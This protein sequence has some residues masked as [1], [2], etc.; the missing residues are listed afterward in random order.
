MKIKV[1]KHKT[2]ALALAV[3][4]FLTS[5]SLVYSSF[6][7]KD[8]N[9]FKDASTEDRRIA[10]EISNETGVAVDQVFDLKI[11][12][13]SW[14]K[15]LEILKTRVNSKEKS[16]KAQMQNTLVNSGLDEDFLKKLKK[17]GFPDESITQVKM[18]EERVVFQLQE[19]S[20][21]SSENQIK[22][23]KPDTDFIKVKDDDKRTFAELTKKID[24][25]DAVY[26]MLKLEK[27]FGS[28]EKVFDEYML[29]LQLDI[30]LNEYIKD[31][32]SY[33]KKRDEKKLLLDEK[34]TITLEKIEAKSIELLQKNNK[35]DD[36]GLLEK[37]AAKSDINKNGDGDKS[38]L[39]DIPHVEVENIKPQNPTD[40]V[41]NEIKEIN[42][43][44]K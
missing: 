44:N 39:P 12:G 30:D 5:I 24:I 32:K 19:I 29:A 25:K 35:S 20:A 8:R 14:E 33:E 34:D 1:K 42:P 23:D 15:V 40:E 41:M 38:Q 13:R 17:E 27:A 9:T 7:E 2:V 3:A 28:Y 4:I 22:V 37:E 16:N 6:G 10:S 36:S 21:D 18:L 26:F 43:M 31:R 11:H